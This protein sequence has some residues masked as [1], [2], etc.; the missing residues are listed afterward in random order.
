VL[1]AGELVVEDGRLTR[2]D[3]ARIHRNANAE[4]PALWQRMKE[5]R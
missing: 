1:V 5:L 4:A 3:L 2:A